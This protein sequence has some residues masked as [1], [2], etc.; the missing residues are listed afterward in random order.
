VPDA[1]RSPFAPT[2]W[3][4]GTVVNERYRLEEIVRRGG[5]GSVWRGLD[6][7]TQEVLAIKGLDP[8]LARDRVMVQRFL[9]EARAARALVSPNV[10]EIRDFGVD[11]D[12]AFIAMELLEGEP[13][14]ERIARVGRLPPEEVFRFVSEVLRAM[15]QAHEAGIIHRD[16]KPDNVFIC[17]GEPEVAKVLDFGIAK[18]K[19]G[20]LWQG[21]GTGTQTGLMLG[22]PYYM[23]P[24]QAQ[25]RALD[26]RTDLWSMAVVA[27]EALL[28]RRPFVADFFGDLVVAICT[29][30]TPIPSSVGPVPPGFDEWFVRGTQ[31]DPARRFQSAREMA[32]EL[33][34]VLGPT[35]AKRF[36]TARNPLVSRSVAPGSALASQAPAAGRDLALTTGQ[37]SVL[38]RAAHSSA[39]DPS[40]KGLLALLALGALILLGVAAFALAGGARALH[41]AELGTAPAAAIPAATLDERSQTDL[42]SRARPS[43][44]RAAAS[45]S[46]SATPIPV[47]R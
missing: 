33:G 31:R 5:M 26:H 10:V 2:P 11:H 45:L 15:E 21:T 8:E 28:G 35:P 44:P 12:H 17:R 38:A 34:A 25:A 46:V 39:P 24:E 3:Q 19:K 47:R 23:S 1:V 6:L 9:R 7:V 42:P 41:E 18:V 29:A 13:L 40:N 27:F 16:L 37:R 43:D 32:E 36:T 20:A 22:T 4:P 30:P 14:R